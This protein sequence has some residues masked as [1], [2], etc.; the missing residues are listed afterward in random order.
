MA[1]A[2]LS[3]YYIWKNI[4]STCKNDKFKISAS[5][6]NDEFDLPD[7]SYSV[8]DIQEAILEQSVCVNLSE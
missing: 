7:E 5:Y 4:K 6:W 8:S 2:N 3:I 1:L